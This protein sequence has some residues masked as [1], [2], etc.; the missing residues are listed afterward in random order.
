MQAR[1][2]FGFVIRH[3][4]VG[5]I[6]DKALIDTLVLQAIITVG[7]GFQNGYGSRQQ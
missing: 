6:V 5:F 2:I 7:M 3:V 4:Q 1:K